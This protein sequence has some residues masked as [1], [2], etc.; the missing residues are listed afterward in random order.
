MNEKAKDDV[1]SKLTRLYM[2]ETAIQEAKKERMAD[3][4]T[5]SGITHD[6]GRSS[7]IGYLH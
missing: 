7:K 4:I 6:D 3:A 2:L 1:Y 5:V